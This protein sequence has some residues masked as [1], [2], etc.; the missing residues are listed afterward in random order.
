VELAGRGLEVVAAARR[1]EQLDGLPATAR[2]TLDVTSDA[3]VQR[4]AEV[5]GPIDLLVNNAAVSVAAPVEDTPVG[6]ALAMLDT[7]V[8]GPLRMISAFA[9]MLLAGDLPRFRRPGPI[10][11]AGLLVLV[12]GWT[13]PTGGPGRRPTARD[14]PAQSC[15]R[16]P[17]SRTTGGS[18]PAPS[19]TARR[20][21]PYPPARAAGWSSGTWRGSCGPPCSSPSRT[22]LVS[23]VDFRGHGHDATV[24]SFS[25]AKS[26]VSA[27]VGIAIAQRFGRITLRHLLTMTSG[28]ADLDPTHRGPA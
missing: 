14:W 23:E 6:V 22:T 2:L 24:S 16:S 10:A 13:S 5:A 18:R 3:S 27:L 15:G 9:L 17:T 26:V 1:V 20:W 7:N 21:R 25:V 8:V 12:L 19:P 28:L 4:A 11:D